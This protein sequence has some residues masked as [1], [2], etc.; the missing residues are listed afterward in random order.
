MN[1]STR[2]A[3]SRLSLAALVAMSG[4]LGTL[5][6]C[7]GDGDDGDDTPL[8]TLDL[9]AANSDT[10]AHATA[11]GFMAFGSTVMMPLGAGD[12]RATAL[13]STGS[14]AWLP[15]RVLS[16][17]LQAMGGA[18]RTGVA[19]PLAVVDL[20]TTPCAVAGNSS[21]SFEDAD[22]DA[23]LDVGEVFTFVFNNCQDNAAS[24]TNGSMSGTVTR[25]NDNGTAF[26][27]GITLA[28]LA[29]TAVDGSH[30]LTLNGD[31]RLG[32]RALSETVEQMTLSANGPVTAVVHTHLPFDDMVT[33]QPG[34][35]QDSTH[36][37][38]VGRST[39]TLTGVMESAQAGGSFAVSTL[40]PIELYDTDSY[41]RIGVVQMLGRTGIMSLQVLSTQ[42]VQVDLDTNGDGNLESSTPRSW[43]WLF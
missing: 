36:D 41:P 4:A 10:V 29:Q 33:L 27:A 34:F 30:S 8:V 28:S 42:Q 18:T 9:T 25:L 40:T 37:Y 26:D 7:G 22:N 39:S 32:Y 20:G 38:S 43:D 12:D 35:V 14:T 1:I 23:M 11:A 13:A 5:V 31:V 21:M 24:V 17:L 2:F 6:G 19:R 3:L 16:G 15:P